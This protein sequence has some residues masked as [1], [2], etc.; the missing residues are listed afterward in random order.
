[1]GALIRTKGTKLLAA[2]FNG[3]FSTWINFY[4]TNATYTGFFNTNSGSYTSLWYLT[5]NAQIT[6][7]NKDHSRRKDGNCL[8]PDIDRGDHPHGPH[9]NL[10]LRWLWFLQNGL[11]APNDQ[12]IAANIYTALINSTYNSI[13]FDVVETNGPQAV[14]ATPSI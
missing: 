14:A 12:T 13:T 4:R 2:H 6:D 9:Y 5:Y 3:E 8:L 10:Q 11:T 1:M 7:S